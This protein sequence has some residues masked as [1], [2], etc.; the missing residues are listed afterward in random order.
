MIDRIKSVHSPNLSRRPHHDGA[1]T[2]YAKN[3]EQRYLSS[4]RILRFI[5]SARLLSDPSLS[6]G[7]DV[8]S[9][10][11]FDAFWRTMIYNRTGD[12]FTEEVVPDSTVGYSFGYWYM[13]WKL[14]LTR[15]WEHNIELFY[16]QREVLQGLMTPFTSVFDEVYGCRSFMVTDSGRLGWAPPAAEPGDVI[17]MFQGNRIPFVARSVGN[18]DAWEY[19]GG[20]YV[21]GCMD[22]EIWQLDRVD[23]E[24]MRFV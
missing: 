17:A 1:G 10:D 21:H 7:D 15:R 14:H 19:F 2:Y 8:M 18:S 6:L 23:W 22:G 16:S 24:F 12:N 3:L 4:I 5:T 20:C 13:Y 11:M 9:G